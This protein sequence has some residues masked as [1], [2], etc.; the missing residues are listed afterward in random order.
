MSKKLVVQNT[1]LLI[2]KYDLIYKYVQLAAHI[3][4]FVLINTDNIWIIH[5]NHIL[6]HSIATNKAHIKTGS[7]LTFPEKK[8]WTSMILNKISIK[9]PCM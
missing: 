1:V 3:Y 8:L 5:Y 6:L 7:S 9:F 2:I 4:V